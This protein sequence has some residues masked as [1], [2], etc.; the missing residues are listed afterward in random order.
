M[1]RDALDY[2]N[3]SNVLVIS[4]TTFHFFCMCLLPYILFLAVVIAIL[5]LIFFWMWDEYKYGLWWWLLV[6]ALIGS[7]IELYRAYITHWLDFIIVTPEKI[8]IHNK[9]DLFHENTKSIYVKNI[10][11]IHVSKEWFRD[12]ILNQ[13]RITIEEVGEDIPHSKIYFWP[14]SY[15]DRLKLKIE[16]VTNIHARN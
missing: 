13:W 11:W 3:S 9:W 12:S 5:W 2:N 15:P 4:K 8:D 14:V 6:F 1:I 10:A 7:M 16:E